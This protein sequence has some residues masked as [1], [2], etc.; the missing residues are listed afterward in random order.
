MPGGVRLCPYIRLLIEPLFAYNHF[1]DDDLEDDDIEV[2][3]YDS[4]EESYHSSSSEGKKV[5]KGKKKKMVIKT[6]GIEIGL[7][8]VKKSN[9]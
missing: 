4:E 9:G 8:V 3:E 2:D 6:D 5:V 1:E 7:N